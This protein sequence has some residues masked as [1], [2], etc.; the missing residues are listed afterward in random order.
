[1]KVLGREA[2]RTGVL[3]AAVIVAAAAFRLFRLDWDA[4][5]HLHPDERFLTM[6]ET[7]LSWP[8]TLST[9]F[10]EAH[11][12]L[13]PRN[14]GFPFYAYG[15]FPIVAVKAVASA[16]H[17]TS[18]D[19]VTLVGRAVS[20]VADLATLAL[21]LL[22]AWRVSRDRRVV[23]LA[24]FF[25]AFAVLPIQ[26]A[27]FFT[28]DSL[29]TCLATAVLLSLVAVQSSPRPAR[30]AWAGA[31]IGLALATKI[32]SALLVLV[33]AVVVAEAVLRA[34]KR[35]GA[36][37][38]AP[39]ESLLFRSTL[40]GIAA[41]SVFRLAQPDAFRG[42]GLL[43]ILP[44]DRWLSNFAEAAALVNGSRD[45]PPGVQWAGR[46]MLAWPLENLVLWGLGVPLGLAALCGTLAAAAAVQ[47]RREG[48][49][50]VPVAWVAVVLVYQGTQWVASMRYFLPAYPALCLLAAW[51]LVRLRDRALTTAARRAAAGA[52]VLTGIGTLLWATAFMRIY[53]RPHPRIEASRWIYANVSPGATIACEHWD[54]PLPLRLSGPDPFPSLYT[55]F[56]LP[57]YD[58]DTPKKLTKVLDGLDHADVLVLSSDRL[59]GSIPR[60]PLRWPMTTRYYEALE[61]GSLGFEE[62]ARFTSRPGLLGL[63]V[64]DE[65]AEE[66][67]TV[68]DHPRVRIFRKTPA[69]SHDRAARILDVDLGRIL[70]MTPREASRAPN[71]LMLSEVA[72]ERVRHRGTWSSLFG[73]AA[74]GA[75]RSV[76]LWS[77][78]LLVLGLV[79]APLTALAC[80]SLPDGGFAFARAVGLLATSW[81]AWL[82]ASL[83]IAPFSSGTLIVALGIL[84]AVS[85]AVAVARRR[86]L[87]ALLAERGRLLAAEELLFWSAFVAFL[88]IRRANPD[89]WHPTLGGEKPMDLAFLTAVVK[90]EDFPPYDPWFAGGALNYYYFGFVLAGALVKLTGVAPAVAYNLA[91]PTFFALT[92]A[93]AFGAALALVAPARGGAGR[94]TAGFAI[95]G[96][97]FVAVMGNLGEVRLYLEAARS[98]S[99][100]TWASP[101]PGLTA[102]VRT[103]TGLLASARAGTPLVAH[104]DW[105][106]WTA[107]R[108]IG[109]AE[110]EPGPIN[111][112]PFF[113]YLFG[114]LHAHALALPLTLLV[115]GLAAAHALAEAGES[116]L[117]E[118]ARLALLALGLG[119][120]VATNTWDAPTYGLLVFVA[121]V[122][123]AFARGDSAASQLR[124][125][126]MRAG[127]VAVGAAALFW[128]FLRSWGRPYG[129]FSAWTGSSTSLGAFLLIHAIFLFVIVLAFA[130][131]LSQPGNREALRN[132][133]TRGSPAIAFARNATG[134]AAF[135]GGI[136][137]L[138]GR[139]VA[140]VLVGLLALTAVVSLCSGHDASWRLTLAGAAT[141]FGVLLSAE[142]IVLTGDVGRMNTVFKFSLQ[143]W[144]LLG[145]ASAACAARIAAVLPGLGPAIRHAFRSAFA[146]LLFGGLLYPLL[147]TPARIRD[148]FDPAGARGLDGSSFLRNAVIDMGGARTP[149][150]WDR[151]AFVWIQEN[152]SGTP[153][154]AEANTDPVLYGWGN[155]YAMFTGLPSVIGWRWHEVQQRAATGAEAID[156]RIADLGRFYRTE[157]LDEAARLAR[158]YNV[159][160]VVV[161][162]LERAI[163]GNT[164]LGKF[165][166]GGRFTLVYENPGVRLY[167]VNPGPRS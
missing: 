133:A 85:A 10:D 67:F 147:A 55:G 115:F 143:A 122:I 5:Q 27:H 107:T 79:G 52:I 162:P 127:L 94:R 108:L 148:R 138:L 46:V 149:L 84:G 77:L 57:W 112:M 166:A 78:L 167:R 99:P 54:D 134:V 16:L 110:A 75:F 140:G 88:L 69:Y 109:H 144:V 65:R 48:A 60:M 97:L 41:F 93:G 36:P 40:A 119:A 39:V 154:V 11:S 26:Q 137:V 160:L 42:P 18:F 68:Y 135:L 114:D 59:S 104:P 3:I 155:R 2:R 156:R 120:L 56:Q 96:A 163:Y 151:Q 58:D 82:V 17:R 150:D 146:L 61:D 91:V 30:F 83:R 100:S 153:V 136:L 51:G 49:L 128:P 14:V 89:L 8:E 111:E 29:A 32:T 21:L 33:A 129:G 98:A 74:P 116:R 121:C 72:W 7:A 25:Y 73:P 132:F 38:G 118:G 70:R 157:D 53:T 141:G 165:A 105:A 31:L 23:L 124:G 139:P 66:A 125:A 113:T 28:V 158:R 80:R 142:L 90:S 102:L 159:E 62:A 95:L 19:E 130:L 164:G 45:I 63:S 35:G 101:V 1:M 12:T 22:L 117:A 44:S 71:G 123:G 145:L 50:L 43:G 131:E 87:K 37:R 86:E 103:A 47:R 76:I 34:W 20:A 152:V 92:V 161:G 126:F 4:R 106:Y 64:P 15:T 24:G 81:I 6:A 9:Y 13:N